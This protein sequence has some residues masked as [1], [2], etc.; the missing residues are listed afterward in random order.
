MAIAFAIPRSSNHWLSVEASAPV[1]FVC[2]NVSFQEKESRM[3]KK[4]KRREENRRRKEKDASNTGE[5]LTN[6]YNG[7][8]KKRISSRPSKLSFIPN[9][10]MHS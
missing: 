8:L 2:L 10:C 5:H 7:G 1:V 3:E 9:F 4:G 6:A